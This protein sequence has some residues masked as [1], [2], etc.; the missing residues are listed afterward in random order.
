MSAIARRLSIFTFL[1]T[2]LV[3]GHAFS[4]PKVQT[5]ALSNPIFQAGT[6]LTVGGPS[7]DILKPFDRL[8]DRRRYESAKLQ[9]TEGCK[10]LR[11]WEPVVVARA[12]WR[13]VVSPIASKS[14]V[15]ILAVASEANCVKVGFPIHVAAMDHKTGLTFSLGYFFPTAI[16][17]SRPEL[18]GQETVLKTAAGLLEFTGPVAFVTGAVISSYVSEQSNVYAPRINGVRI[19]TRDE[20]ETAIQEG[21]QI[22]DVRPPKMFSLVRLK[23]AIDV[24]Y[25]TGPRMKP[26]DDYASY[27]KSGDT[28]DIRKINQ[29]RNQTVILIGEGATAPSPFRAAVV[30]RSEGWKNIYLFYEGMNYFTQMET[31]PPDTSSALK[32]LGGPVDL[33]RYLK[34]NTNAKLFDV[35][36]DREFLDGTVRGAVKAPFIERDDLRLHR[37]N[38]RGKTIT[39]YG[40]IWIAPPGALKT[41]PVVFIGENEFD[42]R[43][44]KAAL[45]A[46]TIGFS[47]VSYFHGGI[48]SWKSAAKEDAENYEFA[49]SGIDR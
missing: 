31:A 27:A 8:S 5:M 41:A 37:T 47:N 36:S 26:L 45:A 7:R 2:A 25:L 29:D 18:L 16:V 46:Q 32:V 20:M 13:S 49:R 35:R 15:G 24:P 28:F 48:A 1:F 12:Q 3:F 38:I 42:W 34:A 21:A 44:F 30:L 11:D 33:A 14:T 17:R 23:G 40:D 10:T 22:A 39:D 9:E 43:P 19:I 6:E 4:A